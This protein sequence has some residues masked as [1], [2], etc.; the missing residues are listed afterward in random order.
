M[1]VIFDHRVKFNKTPVNSVAEFSFHWIAKHSF[2]SIKPRL[3]DKV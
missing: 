1:I 3:F 2:S